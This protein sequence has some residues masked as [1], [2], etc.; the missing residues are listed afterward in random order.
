MNVALR[1]NPFE[2]QLQT[3]SSAEAKIGSGRARLELQRFNR[4]RRR[5][6]IRAVEHVPDKP[7][8]Q[9]GWFPKLSGKPGEHRVPEP[10]G[11][12]GSLRKGWTSN[13]GVA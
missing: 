4:G 6:A 8:T 5:A 10:H 7:A 11:R 2:E 3:N 12:N 9:P 1:A 13:V